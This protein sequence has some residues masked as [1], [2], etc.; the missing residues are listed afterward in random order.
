MPISMSSRP[1]AISV[2][3]EHSFT[4]PVAVC[5]TAGERGTAC[6]VSGRHRKA[7]RV[8][9][10]HSESLSSISGNVEGLSTTCN[11]ASVQGG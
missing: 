11:E 9:R 7:P 6:R 4:V 1:W 8:I 2:F 3:M 10:Q 5:V